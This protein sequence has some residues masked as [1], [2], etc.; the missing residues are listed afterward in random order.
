MSLLRSA[1]VSIVLLSAVAVQEAPAQGRWPEREVRFINPSAPGSGGIDALSRLMVEKLR[2]I[3]GQPV[4]MEN[5]P[6][7]GGSTGI[8]RLAK[9]EPTGYTIGLSGDAA[10]AVNISLYK[11]LPY[12]PVT[13]LA[14]II[15][16]GRTTNL[17]I[18]N[19]QTGPTSLKQLVAMA[20][21][22][23]G[24]I[25]FNSN[26]YGTSQHIG[27]E[28]L[29]TSAGID[30]L[31]TPSRTPTLPDILGGHV[32][33]SFANIMVALPNVRAGKLRALGISSP[34]RSPAAPDIP[35]IAEQGYPGFNASAW[36]GLVAPAGTPD[37][38][39]R[40]I[41]SDATKALADPVFQKQLTDLGFQ[42]EAGGPPEAFA[43][44]IKA[45]I[46]RVAALL[47]N[48]SIKLD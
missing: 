13:S 34:G 3:W 5:V 20:R 6:G 28:L 37:A 16:I 30:I 25:T 36:F 33:A 39:V 43:A 21:E 12:D 27:F 1:A 44:F 38:I 2:E 4:V 46:S 32:T 29:K 11:N 31:H 35:T 48:S 18:V 10:L 8:G 14:P 42:I 40:R 7:T 26:G 24:S 47:K 23:P 19:A 15:L 22:K 17:L 45:E 41:N 9:S